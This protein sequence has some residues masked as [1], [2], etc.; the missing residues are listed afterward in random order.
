MGISK[1]QG[2]TTLL[3]QFFTKEK[4]VLGYENHCREVYNN[5]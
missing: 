1:A 3:T 4:I 5:H 2:Y